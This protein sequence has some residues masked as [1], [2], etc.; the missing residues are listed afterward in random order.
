MPIPTWSEEYSVN[1]KEIDEQH[2]KLLE[3]VSQLHAAV[4]ARI[5]KDELRLMLVDLVKYVRVHFTTEEKYMKKNGFDHIK[6]HQKEH[7]MLL[8]HL[9]QLVKFVSKGN[10]PIFYSDYDISNDGFLAHI[11]TFDKKMGEFL[12]SKEVY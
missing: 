4:E 7:K 6:K 12:N 1:V 3:H 5:D 11:L 10:H 8:K 2:K 9:E